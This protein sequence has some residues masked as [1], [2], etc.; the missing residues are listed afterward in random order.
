MLRQ[1]FRH[2]RPPPSPLTHPLITHPHNPRCRTQDNVP[3][4]IYRHSAQPRHRT[5]CAKQSRPMLS[6]E[7]ARTRL[8]RGLVPV[9]TH[10]IQESAQ[11]LV[12]CLQVRRG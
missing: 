1:P 2:S 5:V 11:V 3:G 8:G 10:D 6:N 4:P 12:V 9:E 7:I